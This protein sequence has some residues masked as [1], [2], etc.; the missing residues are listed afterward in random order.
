MQIYPAAYIDDCN[1][2]HNIFWYLGFYQD[3]DCLDR[4]KSNIEAFDLASGEDDD[5]L[6]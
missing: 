6:L 4:A 5:D 1:N 2:R 3:L